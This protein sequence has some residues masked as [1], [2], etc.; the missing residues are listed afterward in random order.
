MLLLPRINFENIVDDS[1]WQDDSEGDDFDPGDDD[2]DDDDEDE[3]EELD[4]G[5][6]EGTAI[7]TFDCSS[8]WRTVK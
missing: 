3:E 4:D 6:D 1:W 2:D 5:A 7:M 8:Y